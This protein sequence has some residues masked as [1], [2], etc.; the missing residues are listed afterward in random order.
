MVVHRG[1]VLACSEIFIFLKEFDLSFT[2][3]LRFY[4]IYRGGSGGIG[5][6]TGGEGAVG[7]WRVLRRG[8]I[9]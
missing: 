6:R 7:S 5:E 4:T 2:A 9:R 8:E 3:Q 1:S